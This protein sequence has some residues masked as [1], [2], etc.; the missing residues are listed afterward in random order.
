MRLDH[1][2]IQ[3]HI[4]H[5]GRMCLLDEVLEWD[6]QR[7][8][9]RSSSHRSPDNPLRA[10]GRLGAACGIEYAAQSMAVHG[11]LAAAEG[12]GAA[13]RDAAT[14]GSATP[15]SAGASSVGYLASVRAVTLFIQRLY[16]LA[17]DL[18]ATATRI[19]GDNTMVLYA[20]NIAAADQTLLSGRATI[21]FD[22]GSVSTRHSTS[23]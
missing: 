17:S 21:I 4:P 22:I 9:C 20:F 6:A 18:V 2:W 5:A 13:P 19:S 23:T 16:D 7:I 10:H 11:V 3:Q 14:A 8:L 15:R 12:A 1:G